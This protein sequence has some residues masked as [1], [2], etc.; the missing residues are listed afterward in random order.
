[1]GE[2]IVMAICFL[3]MLAVV[4]YRVGQ[5]L[6]PPIVQE[7]GIIKKQ[8]TAVEV[9]LREVSSQVS[10]MVIDRSMRD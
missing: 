7:I 9:E 4:N 8:I 3:A 10:N 1:M 5:Y 2:T 6:N